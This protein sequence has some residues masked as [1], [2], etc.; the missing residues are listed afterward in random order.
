[1]R[2]IR[3]AAFLRSAFLRRAARRFWLTAFWEIPAGRPGLAAICLE[4]SQVSSLLFVLFSFDINI[5]PFCS[6]VFLFCH[7]QTKAALPRRR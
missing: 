3:Q 4:K 7:K 5:I 2:W 6:L 1:M